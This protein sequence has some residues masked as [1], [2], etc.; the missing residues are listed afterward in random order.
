[1]KKRIIQWT[2]P[3]LKRV[4]LRLA[5][6]KDYQ[7][8]QKLNALLRRLINHAKTSSKTDSDSI[9]FCI[10][11]KDRA[12]QL[13]GLLRS[14]LC[15]IQGSYSIQ[16][17]Y[18]ASNDQHAR[19]YQEAAEEL[20]RPD[21]IQWTQENNF[22]DDLIQQLKAIQTEFVC[23]LVDDIVFI[24]PIDL[25]ALDRPKIRKGIVSL[26]L[27]RNIDYCYTKQKTMQLPDLRPANDSNDL[28]QF[29]WTRGTYDWAYPLS[30]D[31]HIF[32][33]SE[34]QITV[35]HL[36]FR[37]PNSFERALQIL[38]PLYQARA[39]YCF[40]SPIILNI[41]LNRVQ[42]ENDNISGTIT[43]EYLLQKWQSGQRLH[44]EQLADIHTQSVHEEVE[45]SFIE[46]VHPP[47]ATDE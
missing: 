10:F 32:L 1:M 47:Q 41:P 38:T 39:G 31:G 8:T 16:V 22:S 42:G 11:S 7:Q 15:H 14:M 21:L 5:R 17:I 44:F 26:R 28:L 24:R 36:N 27:G 23:F 2:Q 25:D 33:T 4:G 6:E 45:I 37:A 30:V 13:D 29:D 35:E 3:L 43:P 12:L 20:K 40:A 9:T 18:S 34:I 19:A 46:R